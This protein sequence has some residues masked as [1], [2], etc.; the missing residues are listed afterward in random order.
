[1]LVENRPLARLLLSSCE[2]GRAI[3]AEL[4]GAVAEVLAYVTRIK[5][6]SHQ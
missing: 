1:M 3:P 6:G 5:E 2:I 4:Y